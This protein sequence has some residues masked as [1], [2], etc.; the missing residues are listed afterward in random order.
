[1]NNWS[2]EVGCDSQGRTYTIRAKPDFA[3][4]NFVQIGVSLPLL[5]AGER[6]NNTRAALV[7]L[8]LQNSECDLKPMSLTN[9]KS[10]D[11]IRVLFNV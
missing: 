1:M 11:M 6:E 3:N 8:T 2:Q 4:L 5:G 9:T 7:Q 10:N